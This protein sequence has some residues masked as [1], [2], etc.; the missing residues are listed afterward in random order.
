[1]KR[2]TLIL[3]LLMLITTPVYAVQKTEEKIHF[4][5][6]G[7]ADC[8]LVESNGMYMLIDGGEEDDGEPIIKYLKDNGVDK[9]TY[10]IATHPHADHIGG[11][12]DVIDS[13]V[14]E[15]VIMPKVSATTYCFERMINSIARSKAK[16][17]EPVQGAVYTL[18]DF[19]FTILGPKHYDSDDLNNDSVAI[20]LVNKNDSFI[21][22][23]DAQTEEE[24]DIIDSGIDISADVLKVGHH[25]SH[26][27]TSDAFLNK[28]A[29]EY[30]VI[31]VGEDNSYGHPAPS[32]MEKLN[33]RNIKIYRTDIHDTVTAVSTGNGITFTENSVGGG[34]RQSSAAVGGSVRTAQ[35]YIL[36]KNS[37]KFHKDTCVYGKKTSPTNKLVYT[38]YADTI[39]ALGYTPCKVCNP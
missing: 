3:A 21:F 4:I 8:T 24:N 7:Q 26:S 31:S 9:L 6:V 12:D 25:G 39:K 29:P 11:I 1:M 36:N 34:A 13:F 17:I 10:I 5:D 22:T 30:A 16:V 14:T 37:M 32:T 28:V 2:I 15:N 19:T 23:G 33:N 18:G 38:G 20:K 35:T 27:S